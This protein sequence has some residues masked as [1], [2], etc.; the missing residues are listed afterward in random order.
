VAY[1]TAARA[2]LD[3][4]TDD[5]LAAGS[6]IALRR[7]GS[8][9]GRCTIEAIAPHHA[10]C[11]GA[12]ARPGDSFDLPAVADPAPP[13]LLPPPPSDDVLAHRRAVVAATP[14]MM[15][16]ATASPEAP[17]VLPRTRAIDVAV[18]EQAWSVNPGGVSSKQSL[19]IVARGVPLASWLY[20]DL[21]ARL[22]HWST[23]QNPVFRPNDKTQVY[24]WQAQLTAIPSDRLTLAG[25]RVLPWG[26]PGA[27]IF[28]GAMAGWHGR[29]GDA[30]TEVGVFGG[31]VPAPDTT[32]PDRQRYTGGAYWSLDRR[33]GGLTLRSE[34]RLAAVHTPELGTRGEASVTGR[35]FT[36]AFDLS[37]EAGLGAGGK[38]HAPSYLDALRLDATI[39]PT[40]GL[41]L[42][43][44]FRYAG[45]VWPQTFF[46]PAFPGRNREADAFASYD[47]G[48]WLRLGVTGGTSADLVS[49]VSRTWVGPEVTL[50]RI[51][52]G[53][54]TLGAGYLEER[55]SFAGRS[56]YLQ[57]AATPAQWLWLLA[58]AG[59][60]HEQGDVVIQDE[61]SLTLGARAELTSWLALRL[62]VTD[63][64]ALDSGEGSQPSSLTA[65]GTLQGAF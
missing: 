56:A 35:A 2:Y 41:R 3:A 34:G 63:R 62:T 7:N 32:K 37:V 15:I 43:G 39:R 25:G 33:V 46:P 20:L 28:D 61:A 44:S 27:T 55:G 51:L 57:L 22:E 18:T 60:S 13:P 38:A 9:A 48:P 16:V 49:K 12:R 1:V 50:T 17:L 31:E 19:D 36:R 8:A 23:R 65:F 47:V 40:A 26:I 42:G 11:S 21:D 4:G 58:R 53:R 5:G 30:S 29:L 45:L 6:E 64:V 59:W 24:I 52:W 54:G 10:V 14:V